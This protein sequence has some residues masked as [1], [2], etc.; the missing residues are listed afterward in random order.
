[1]CYFQWPLCVD[2]SGLRTD[3]C[4]HVGTNQ[5]ANR[6]RVVNPLANELFQRFRTFS[7][8]ALPQAAVI[9]ASHQCAVRMRD[10]PGIADHVYAH[11][12]VEKS[13]EMTKAFLSSSSM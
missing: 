12:V 9:E 1:M 10:F 3:P 8:P 11:Q 2:I 7:L 5:H 13:E 6:R 4:R